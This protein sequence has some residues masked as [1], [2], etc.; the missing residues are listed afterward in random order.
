MLEKFFNL[1]N[2]KKR[3]ELGMF[4]VEE[5]YFQWIPY[6]GI[7]LSIHNRSNFT[8]ISPYEMYKITSNKTEAIVILKYNF[9]QFEPSK[10]YI[11]MDG[12]QDYG[13]IGSIIRTAIAFNYKNIIYLG[14]KDYWHHKTIEASR[15]LVLQYQPPIF[16][17][18]EFLDFVK[19]NNIEIMVAHNFG[20]SHLPKLNKTTAIIFGNEK[21]GVTKEIVDLGFK[22]TIPIEI[23]S[24]NVSV[25]AGIIMHH[26]KCKEL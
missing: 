22:I 20:G 13:N 7:K 21:T 15:G 19:K 3:K 1:N 23:E 17:K 26:I 14:E 5:K 4:F 11:V 25:A 8:L 16:S 9:L 24:L 6:D 12:L 10:H 2:E 18:E